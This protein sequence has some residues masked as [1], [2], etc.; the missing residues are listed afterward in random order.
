MSTMSNEARNLER[1]LHNSTVPNYRQISVVFIEVG[2]VFKEDLEN[3]S[4]V[5]PRS[6]NYNCM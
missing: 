4:A 6:T 1:M 2:L 3:V 5:V